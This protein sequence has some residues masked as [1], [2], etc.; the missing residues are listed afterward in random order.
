MIGATIRVR[1][2]KEAESPR[3]P[4]RSFGPANLEITL[5]RSG[6]TIPD[7]MENGTTEA[8]TIFGDVA[9][10]HIHMERERSEKERRIRFFSEIF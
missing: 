2:P 4:P 10:A 7:A 3:N 1:D 9:H 8:I 6:L 5:E